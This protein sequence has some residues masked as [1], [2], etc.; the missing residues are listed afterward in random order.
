MRY[1]TEENPENWDEENPESEES[2]A[3]ES[4]TGRDNEAGL[5]K[6]LDR[7]AR[8]HE[9]TLA[10]GNY[11]GLHGKVK[12]ADRLNRCGS[13]LVFRH[14]Y[15]VDKVRLHAAD[16]CNKHLL[17]P[18]CA[19]LRGSKMVRA[20]LDRLKTI[21]AQQ[22]P[23]K[24]Y[25]VTFTVKNG[26]DLS[27]RFIHLQNSLKRLH[28]KRHG[29]GQ[30]TEASKA[31]GA[32][33]SYEFK[34]GKN[35][36]LWHPH[37]HAIWLC[38]EAPDVQKLRDEWLAITGDSHM[39]DVTEFHNQDDVIT[40]FLEVFKYAVKFSDLPLADNWHGFEVLG[41]K[42]LIAS[43]GLFRGVEIPEN[44]TDELVLDDL[45]YVEWMYRYFQNHGYELD[46]SHRQI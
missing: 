19:I 11:A 35:S 40:G 7:Y 43:F 25:L 2:L 17:C 10:M 46:D 6:R 26:F 23:L 22:G 30:F 8:A 33:W 39:M 27:E 13:Y 41:G 20:Y 34:R 45:P 31:L 14:Y 9:R 15:T 38:K 21:I 3:A 24:A 28:K 37:V 32:V 29:K 16:F 4:E 44:L 5:P 42:R 1:S 36:G 12:I 18:L